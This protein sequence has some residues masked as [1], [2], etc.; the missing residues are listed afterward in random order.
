ML[1]LSGFELYS[2][3]VPMTSISVI[4]I[5]SKLDLFLVF[6]SHLRKLRII[7]NLD[8]KRSTPKF[9]T[10]LSVYYNAQTFCPSGFL[11]VQKGYKNSK[12]VSLWI[13][14]I[15]DTHFRN[16]L[17]SY[18][19]RNRQ[20]NEDPPAI[21]FGN[22]LRKQTNNKKNN[23]KTKNRSHRFPPISMYTT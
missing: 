16:E 1:C 10:S 13:I 23:K 5:S 21:F 19:T 7:Y 4:R 22:D 18:R 2:R 20:T 17:Q 3:W 6:F 12:P 9:L 15:P 8:E 14:L 11:S